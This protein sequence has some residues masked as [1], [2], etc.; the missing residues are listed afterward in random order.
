MLSTKVNG[1]EFFCFSGSVHICVSLNQL[2]VPGSGREAVVLRQQFTAEARGSWEKGVRSLGAQAGDVLSVAS[3][4][5]VE[6][7]VCEP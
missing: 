5:V 4:E 1:I 3:L 6:V 2:H 7:G